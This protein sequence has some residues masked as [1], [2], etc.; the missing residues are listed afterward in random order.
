MEFRIFMTVKTVKNKLSV[1]RF[2]ILVNQ[3]VFFFSTKRG[4]FLLH[5]VKHENMKPD[6]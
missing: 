3:K 1:I 2:I 6:T 5:S 4:E